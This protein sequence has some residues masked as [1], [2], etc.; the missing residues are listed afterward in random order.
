MKLTF[1]QTFNFIVLTLQKIIYKKVEV[2]DRQLV[3]MNLIGN[4][5]IVIEKNYSAR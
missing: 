5:R 2:G 1:I 3:K 4:W